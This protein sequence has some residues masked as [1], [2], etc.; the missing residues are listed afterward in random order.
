MTA[1]DVGRRRVV[2]R[3]RGS[4]L[5]I[6][7]RSA[8]V[9]LIVTLV[10]VLLGLLALA[11]G[12]FPITIAEVVGVLTG[13]VDALPRIVVLEWRLPRAAAAVLFGAALAVAG[14]IFQTVTRNPL[15]SPDIIGLANG[16]FTG[17]LVALLV[18]GGSWPL[19]TAG[20]LI[21]GLL[22]AVLI[23]LLAYRGGLHGFRFI[24]VGIG[25]SAMLASVNTWM[26]LRVELETALFASAWGAGT[27]NSVTALTAVPA[28]LCIVLLLALL[29]LVAPAMRQLDLGDDAASASGVAVGRARLLAIALA[30]CLV[31][32]VTAVAG[33]IAFVALAA[34]QITRRLTQSPGIPL[35]TTGLVG[36]ALLLGSDLIAQ[37]VIPLTVPVGVVTVV[38]GGGYL[39]WLLIHESR[40]RA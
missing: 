37:H 28:G 15:A 34:P 20:S 19:L 16:S 11:L 38:L 25:I 5:V 33:P 18:L 6:G 27:M 36:G 29:P 26:L 39:V 22:A 1:L 3:I 12:D 2:L 35:V 40:R 7:V 31:S 9:G 17:M 32:V 24:V 8:V 14:A 30:V 4:S 10:T 13:Q 23:Y 21:G